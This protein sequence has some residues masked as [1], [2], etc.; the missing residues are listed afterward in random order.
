MDAV[1]SQNFQLFGRG[2]G[3]YSLVLDTA[4]PVDKHS[5]T[6]T[7]SKHTIQNSAA[8]SFMLLK[9]ENNLTK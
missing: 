7:N 1:L 4:M 5:S 2:L 6:S 9:E 3:K 8:A